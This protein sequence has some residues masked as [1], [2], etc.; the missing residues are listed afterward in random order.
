MN[1]TVHLHTVLR[2][3]TPDGRQGLLALSLPAGSTVADVIEQL[4]IAF[5]LDA[6]LLVVNRKSV[7]PGH[8]LAD[9]D[10]LHLMP[11]LAGGSHF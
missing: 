9:G 11:A 3:P 2:R 10:V 8:A 1:V 7:A 5:P 6:L 4:E